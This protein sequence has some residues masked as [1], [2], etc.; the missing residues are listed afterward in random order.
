MEMA[1]GVSPLQWHHYEAELGGP[2]GRSMKTVALRRS[3]PHLSTYLLQLVRL[4]VVPLQL[5]PQ[6]VVLLREHLHHLLR[7]LHDGEGV[8]RQLLARQCWRRWLGRGRGRRRGQGAR[9]QRDGGG[10]RGHGAVL[11]GWRR[12]EGRLALSAAGKGSARGEALE[13]R[14]LETRAGAL[15]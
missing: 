2:K 6:H 1:T 3:P 9:E 15:A 14:A 11:L 10:L 8:G 7:P 13:P 4:L 12:W 5:L